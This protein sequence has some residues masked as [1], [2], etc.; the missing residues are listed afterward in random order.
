M[1]ALT[2]LQKS[3]DTG[4]YRVR[5]IIPA[6]MRHAFGGRREYLKSL[7]TREIGRARSLA[8]P[9]LA[10]LQVQFDRIDGQIIPEGSG[11][12]IQDCVRGDGQMVMDAC[13]FACNIAPLRGDFRVQ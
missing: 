1:R 10:D 3:P 12:V 13:K 5:R 11:E 8:M 7:G 9:I 2:Y 6:R 4:V